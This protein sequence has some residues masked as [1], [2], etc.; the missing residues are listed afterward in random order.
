MDILGVRV[1]NLEKKEILEKV[2]KYNLQA[3]QLHGNESVEFVS[4]LK[5]QL[6]K[7]ICQMT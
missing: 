7:K 4:D 6:P 3:V 2:K 5:K 1:D